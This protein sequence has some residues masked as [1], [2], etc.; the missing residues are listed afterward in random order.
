MPLHQR[1]GAGAP[2]L[3]GGGRRNGAGID[4]MEVPAGRQ[5]IGP[6]AA[7]RPAG[8]WRHMPSIQCC[9]DGVLLC[10]AACGEHRQE[11]V[12]DPRE[13]SRSSGPSGLANHPPAHQSGGESL[14]PFN[15]VTCCAPC[16]RRL[17]REHLGARTAIRTG[18]IACQGIEALKAKIGGDGAMQGSGF[19]CP[20]HAGN[21]RDRNGELGSLR[22]LR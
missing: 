19:G 4:R 20:S 14:D 11:S 2:D 10:L 13:H 8:S 15:G 12:V 17:L 16:A 3:P 1:F 22:V 9:E 18:E 6:T 5:N 21:P 7:G